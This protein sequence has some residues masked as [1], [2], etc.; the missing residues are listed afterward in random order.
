MLQPMHVIPGARRKAVGKW[1]IAVAAAGLWA[2]PGR[3]A[4]E[5]QRPARPEKPAVSLVSVACDRLKG[6]LIAV[7]L[8]PGMT[9]EEADRIIGHLMVEEG[10]FF[11]WG[12]WMVF[13]RYGF[14]VT[15]GPNVSGQW[16]LKS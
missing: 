6:C 9:A 7:Q 16:C 3:S 5:A 13:R 14:E 12:C 2:G 15:E 4:A 8:R 1:I 11:P 10:Q